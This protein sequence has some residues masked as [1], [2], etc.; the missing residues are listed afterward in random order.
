MEIRRVEMT[1]VD[2]FSSIVG[3]SGVETQF[4]EIF[5]FTL[6]HKKIGT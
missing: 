4:R 6:V 5:Y 2:S 3:A 1:G